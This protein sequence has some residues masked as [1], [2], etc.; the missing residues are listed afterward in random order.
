MT[1]KRV[2]KHP[3]AAW[4]AAV[5]GAWLVAAACRSMQSEV[6]SGPA[7]LSTPVLASSSAVPPPSLRVG[8]LP[9]VER[10][11]IDAGSGVVVR[12]RAPGESAVLVRSLARATLQAAGPGRVRLVETGD[13]L[14]GA[15]ALP[16]VPDELLRADTL[17]YRGLLEV[18]PAEEGKLTVVNVVNL[19]DY[20]RGVVPNELSPQA[21][22]EIEALKAQAV[23]ART[24]ALAHLGDYSSKGYDV[25]ATPACQVYRGQAS[26]HR[27]TDRAVEETRGVVATWRGRPIR[28][29]Y[30]STCGGHTEGGKAIFDDA[31]PYLRGVTC[32]P[33]RASR[34]T[35]RTTSAP[36]QKLPRETAQEV[37][38]LQ[39]LG[40]V[41]DA[42]DDPVRLRG[43]P[44]DAEVRDWTGRLQAALRP[45]VD[46][47]ADEIR[48]PGPGATR[49]ETFALMA[50]VV[51][52]RGSPRL[53]DG[54]LAG[55]AGGQLSVLHREA[56]DS[57]PL[58]PAV[59]LFRDV[60]GVHEGRSELTLSVGDRV[61]YVEREGRIVYLESEQA[62]R[63]AADGFASRYYRWEARLTPSD[64]ARSVA[65]YGSVGRVQDIVPKRLG[66]SGRV[67]ELDVVGSKGQIDLKGLQVRWGLGLRENLFVI[68]RQTGAH[69]EVER[70]VITGKGFGHGVGLCQVGAFGMAQTG[71]TFEQILKHYYTGI[72]L[73]RP[74][75]GGG[76]V[77]GRP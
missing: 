66:V 40:I 4:A 20:L 52:E 3:G 41:D 64:V 42:E 56:A 74:E 62:P 57:H 60:D 44:S 39:S 75:A 31:A 43:N 23:A 25:C 63:G 50:A 12:G 73:S 24:Y 71:S 76:A 70:F 17:P 49:A 58:D 30:T 34:L 18:R 38:L 46:G 16:S 65:R 29:Y 36:P 55:L 48:N 32:L 7:G 9:S 27:L 26:E 13:E 59:R 68:D 33:E 8:V 11:V 54:E 19:E 61:V 53:A 47:R 1:R 37:A 72:Q 5:V 10:T 21:F 22:P 14:E 67:V 28:A 77:V 45:G 2:A 69:G 6:L 15:F 35:V 51:E